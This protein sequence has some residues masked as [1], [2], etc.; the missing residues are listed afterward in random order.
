MNKFQLD[1]FYKYS[2]APNGEGKLT[3][4]IEIANDGSFEGQIYDHASRS[5]KQI[6]KGHFK[7]EEGLDKLL[8]LKFP[9]A[10]NLANLAY[11][12]KKDSNNLIEGKYSGSWGALPVKVEFNKDY[13]LFIV[14]IDM[15]VCSIGDSA[16][17]MLVR[18]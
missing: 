11:S 17:L 10:S 14:R 4:E 8:F 3:G 16:E 7:I 13:G 12:L 15:S 2:Q 1:G 6:L 18:K 9:S 5:P